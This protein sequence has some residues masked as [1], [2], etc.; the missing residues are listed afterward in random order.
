MLLERCKVPW[1]L[2]D[3]WYIQHKYRVYWQLQQDHIP[4][5]H[6]RSISYHSYYR[7][8]TRNELRTYKYERFQDRWICQK[9]PP[10]LLKLTIQHFSF[11]QTLNRDFCEN[12]TEKYNWLRIFCYHNKIVVISSSVISE[13]LSGF[14]Y[15]VWNWL[16]Q[17]LVYANKK[18]ALSNKYVNTVNR[19]WMYFHCL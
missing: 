18:L 12:S 17:A 11:S 15:E 6:H 16:K 14:R 13:N 1:K 7:V 2:F 8:C 9:V 19:S 4:K 3:R 10:V 5:F